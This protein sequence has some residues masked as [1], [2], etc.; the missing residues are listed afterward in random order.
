[1]TLRWTAAVGLV[2]VLLI[3][4]LTLRPAPPHTDTAVLDFV[5]KDASGRDVNLASFK[6]KPLI[7][8][9]WATWCGPC[10]V[11]TPYLEAFSRKYEGQGL[12]ILGLETESEPAAILKFAS[13]YKVTYP[14][15]VA[16]QRDDVKT[17]FGWGGILPT[18]VFIRAD[19]TIAAT[20]VGLRSEE[21]W[22]KQIR[23]LF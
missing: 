1:M 5:L 9:F 23:A 3:A 21:F 16:D 15:L 7:V 20:I 13:E 10:K 17:A 14:L 11:E 19:G 12:T 6:G 2:L 18:S 4:G 22:D 8:N